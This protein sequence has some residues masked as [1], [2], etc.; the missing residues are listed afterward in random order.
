MRGLCAG[1][2]FFRWPAADETLAMQ[3]A[4]IL[5]A[6]GL[7]AP[8]PSDRPGV[9]LVDGGCAAVTCADLFLMNSKQLS[10][11]SI[12]YRIQ[13]STELEYFLPQDKVP[14]AMSGPAELTLSL[15]PYCGRNHMYLGRAVAAKPTKYTVEEQ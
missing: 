10:P 6:A 2:V 4:E 9:Q 13:S 1:V 12:R 3:P 5:A 8:A 7:T 14:I 15:P 11:R